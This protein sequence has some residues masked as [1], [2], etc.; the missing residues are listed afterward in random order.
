[1]KREKRKGK[2]R[3]LLRG[4][5]RGGRGVTPLQRGA[6]IFGLEQGKKK[7]EHCKKK[8]MEREGRG[9]VLCSR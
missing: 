2:K 9:A 6:I 4:E 5:G 1:M 8:T 7:E 3:Q